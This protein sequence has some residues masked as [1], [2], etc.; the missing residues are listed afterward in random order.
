MSYEVDFED[1]DEN[2]LMKVFENITDMII[3]AIKDV[4]PDHGG[5]VLASIHYK[6]FSDFDENKRDKSRLALMYLQSQLSSIISQAGQEKG[7]GMFLYGYTRHWLKFILIFESECASFLSWYSFNK[8]MKNMVPYISQIEEY[9]PVIV[10][11]EDSK[12]L[13]A[14]VIKEFQTFADA[15]NDDAGEELKNWLSNLMRQALFYDDSDSKDLLQQ[16][17][18]SFTELMK[19]FDEDFAYNIEF[20]TLFHQYGESWYNEIKK[21]KEWLNKLITE[22]DLFKEEKLE[23]LVRG[24]YWRKIGGKPLKSAILGV[25]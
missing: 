7:I 12:G 16:F 13:P 3:N 14:N 1:V 24:F 20:N 23:R 5:E 2:D 9:L 25:N 6:L 21:R 11:T 17:Q 19:V 15:S 18:K 10:N 8:E 22:L 4:S